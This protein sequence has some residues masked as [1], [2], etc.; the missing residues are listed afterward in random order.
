MKHT[1][2]QT[3]MLSNKRGCFTRINVGL[4]RMSIITLDW[5]MDDTQTLARTCRQACKDVKKQRKPNGCHTN[6]MKVY[7]KNGNGCNHVSKWSQRPIST[8]PQ[9]VQ[10]MAKPRSRQANMDINHKSKQANVDM[11]K[12]NNPNPLYR[13]MCINVGLDHKI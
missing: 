7:L 9:R 3:N 5:S 13:P 2:R 4:D 1:K 8:S 12:G 6:T 11:H 10:S